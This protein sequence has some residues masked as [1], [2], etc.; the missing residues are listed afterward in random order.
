MTKTDTDRYVH[1]RNDQEYQRLRL[2]A[3]MWQDASGALLDRIGLAPG[4]SCLDV[5]S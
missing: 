4:M 3:S 1:A 2:Q 5:G